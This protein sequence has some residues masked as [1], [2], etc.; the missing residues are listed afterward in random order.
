MAI[1]PQGKFG[2]IRGPFTS[3]QDIATIIKNT[4]AIT[5]TLYV[6]LGVSYAEKDA[7]I[8]GKSPEG[9]IPSSLDMMINGNSIWMGRTDMYETDDFIPLRSFTFPQG[10]PASTLIEYRIARI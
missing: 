6:E 5:G 4:E 9:V 3:N 10:A 2:Q 7:M 1:D 8:Y